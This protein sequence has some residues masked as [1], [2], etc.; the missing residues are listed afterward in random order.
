MQRAVAREAAAE[1]AQAALGVRASVGFIGTCGLAG[2]ADMVRRAAA[3]G[4]SER[5]A[6]AI[7]A[8]TDELHALRAALLPAARHAPRR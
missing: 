1:P 6:T 3:E 8:V 4:R 5:A 2:L 7:P